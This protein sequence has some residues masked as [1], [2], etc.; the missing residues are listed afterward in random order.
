[1]GFEVAEADR[2]LQ[3]ELDACEGVRDLARDELQ[4]AALGI[5]DDDEAD[6]GGEPTRVGSEVV[7]PAGVRCALDLA[8]LLLGLHQ[9][10]ALLARGQ[11]GAEVDEIARAATE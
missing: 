8:H 5:V 2:V 3:P 10:R 9:V 11:P 7:G 6:A 4:P 1:S